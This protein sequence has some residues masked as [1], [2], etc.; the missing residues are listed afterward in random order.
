VW[1]LLDLFQTLKLPTAVLANAALYNYCSQE[2][3]AFRA[4]GDEMV[5]H[6]RSNSERQGT[7]SEAEE[8]ALISETTAVMARAEGRPPA[9]WLGPWISESHHTP[10]LLKEAGYR[11]LLDWCCDDSRSGSK[12][13][14]A[15]SCR[16]RT[17]RKSTT[18]RRSSSAARAPASSPK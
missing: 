16:S 7:L 17:R 4:R 9:G 3:A 14:R 5:A 11:Y 15:P 6:G 12:P 18:F 1:R 8:R 10:D 13:V 2:L